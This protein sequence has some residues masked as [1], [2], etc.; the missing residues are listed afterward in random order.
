MV[1]SIQKIYKNNVMD[2][3][4][5]KEKEYQQRWS[6]DIAKHLIKIIQ[7]TKLLFVPML[8]IYMI[9]TLIR[10]VLL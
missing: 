6:E 5:L 7:K 4:F 8:I 10:G 9:C 2:G 3:K 1:G